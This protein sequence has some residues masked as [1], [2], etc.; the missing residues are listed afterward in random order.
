[1]TFLKTEAKIELRCNVYND[2]TVK[3]KCCIQYRAE[4][5]SLIIVLS[6]TFFW[7]VSFLQINYILRMMFYDVNSAMTIIK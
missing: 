6:L 7:T 4:R 5:Y 2:V 1:M 3:E